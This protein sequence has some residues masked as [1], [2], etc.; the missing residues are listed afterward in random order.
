MRGNRHLNA[1]PVTLPSDYVENHGETP[2]PACEPVT[3]LPSQRGHPGNAPMPASAG[4]CSASE[5]VYRS[6][7][8]LR[9]RSRPFAAVGDGFGSRAYGPFWRFV[10]RARPFARIAP[11]RRFPSRHRRPC[12]AP[13][14]ADFSLPSWPVAC[15]PLTYLRYARARSNQWIRFFLVT[16]FSQTGMLANTGS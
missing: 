8:P 9:F 3:R 7:A 15:T 2:F 10:A 6:G 13:T 12:R 1:W 11:G 16:R 4:I 14:V 5:R